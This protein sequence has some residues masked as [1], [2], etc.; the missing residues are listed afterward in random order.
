MTEQRFKYW[1]RT[2]QQDLEI[3]I[4]KELLKSLFSVCGKI[5]YKWGYLIYLPAE[6]LFEGK[7]FNVV[8]WYIL[9]EERSLKHILKVQND[10]KRLA[11]ENKCKYIKQYSHFNEQ[12]NYLLVKDGYKASEYKKEV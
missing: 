10:I 6:S 5:D 7:V 4:N 11:K 8:S 9:P 1:T 3:K 12:L 2:V